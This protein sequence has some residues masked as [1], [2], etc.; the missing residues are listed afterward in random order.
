MTEEEQILAAISASL[1]EEK[2]VEEVY[3]EDEEQAI[4]A[5]LAAMKINEMDDQL[6]KT[7]QQMQKNDTEAKKLDNYSDLLNLDYI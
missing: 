7:L 3:Y 2:K 5:S 1:H 6:E 4:N